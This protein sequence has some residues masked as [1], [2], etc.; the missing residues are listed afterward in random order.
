MAKQRS[1]KLKRL[2]HIQELL[3]TLNI[4]SDNLELYDKAITHK[5]YANE[6]LKISSGDNE[7]LEFLGD[8]ILSAIITDYLFTKFKD[9]SE[10]FLTKL[11]S[12]I[13]SRKNTANLS[14]A[15]ELNQFIKL[16]KGEKKTLGRQRT[17]ILS[18]VFEALIG[19]IYLD[20]GYN[21]TKNFLIPKLKQNIYN[22]HNKKMLQDYK[23]RL[24]EYFL[25]KFN[26]TP[27][28]VV[29]KE[30]GTD[31]SKIFHIQVKFRDKTF[32]KGTG[33]SKKSAAQKA[34]F[35]ALKKLKKI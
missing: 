19:A 32:G 2:I 26:K 33:K 22:I 21:F 12:K 6:N 5:S 14:K 11:R 17:S 16:S 9:K 3:K 23:S 35:D 1:G 29:I 34:A 31:H 10:G 8:S 27:E 25:K 30:E 13:V 15:W 18:N 4:T 7:R 24:Q 28:Y 20:K